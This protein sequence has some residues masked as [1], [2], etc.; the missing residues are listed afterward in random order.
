METPKRCPLFQGDKFIGEAF[1]R[2]TG[3]E[4]VYPTSDKCDD[5]LLGYLKCEYFSRWYW[6]ESAKI[7]LGRRR[8]RAL[9]IKQ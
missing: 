8:R 4:L 7:K 2:F 5:F 6:G 1:C 9:I 3:E